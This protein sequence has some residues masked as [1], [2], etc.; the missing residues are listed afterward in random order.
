VS[1]N[2]VHTAF[3]S[4]YTKTAQITMQL[5]NH[6]LN[7]LLSVKYH[8]TEYQAPYLLPFAATNPLAV[9]L[10]L[11]HPCRRRCRDLCNPTA[12]LHL[13]TFFACVEIMVLICVAVPAIPSCPRVV[14]HVTCGLLLGMYLL[15]KHLVAVFVAHLVWVVVEYCRG[16]LM[17]GCSG[18]V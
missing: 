2:K 14:L 18:S 16:A 9:F 10:A 1:I 8:N 11:H 17:F 5:F 12:R 4:M 15:R 13:I 6:P 3:R 7:L